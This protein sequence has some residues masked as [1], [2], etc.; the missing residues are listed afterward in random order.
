MVF[1]YVFVDGRV[2]SVPGAVA[3]GGR[4]WFLVDSWRWTVVYRLPSCVN[5]GW[6]APGGG[7]VLVPLHMG[8]RS[9][10]LPT[11]VEVVCPGFGWAEWIVGSGSVCRRGR[12]L[13]FEGIGIVRRRGSGLPGR[14]VWSG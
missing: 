6:T 5:M 2:P 8:Y 3:R 11:R 7:V 1:I 14:M 9:C 10:E 12:W 4:V 13:A